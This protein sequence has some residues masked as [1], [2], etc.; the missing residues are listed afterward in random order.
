MYWTSAGVF[1]SRCPPLSRESIIVEVFFLT[2][3]T[4]DRG[5]REWWKRRNRQLSRQSQVRVGRSGKF[6]VLSIIH[7]GGYEWGFRWGR[8]RTRRGG[9]E[10]VRAVAVVETC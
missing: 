9:L 7:K 1:P 3:L 5:G 6:P 4:P 10:V 8:Y 2:L